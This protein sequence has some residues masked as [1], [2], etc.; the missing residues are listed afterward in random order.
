M[1]FI[2]H[3]CFLYPRKKASTSY[4]FSYSS[5]IQDI[6]IHL[7]PFSNCLNCFNVAE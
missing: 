7:V 1:R 3:Y 2:F 4:S 6:R 5:E